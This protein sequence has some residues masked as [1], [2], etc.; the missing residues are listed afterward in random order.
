MPEEMTTCKH[1]K[2]QILASTAKRTGGYCMP[3]AYLGLPPPKENWG[4]II[5]ETEIDPK[6]IKVDRSGL[7]PHLGE[8]A[9]WDEFFATIRPG[10]KVIQF[11]ASASSRTQE[12]VDRT[13]FA[14]VRNGEWVKRIV[15]GRELNPDYYE[16]LEEAVDKESFA[17]DCPD[18]WSEFKDE[19]KSD[20]IIVRFETSP[21]SWE[22]SAGR[23]GYAIKRDGKYVKTYL[24]AS[25]QGCTFRLSGMEGPPP[26][27]GT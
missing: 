8:G 3:H 5:S 1:C 11:Q 14:I 4:T 22:L 13:G 9:K 7:F 26:I 19:L 15:T 27:T 12:F 23:R 24:V 25:K 2:V 17:R 10:D 21:E 16:D 6:D 20:D 18:I